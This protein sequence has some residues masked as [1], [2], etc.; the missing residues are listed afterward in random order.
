[1]KSQYVIED[2][3]LVFDYEFFQDNPKPFFSVAKARVHLEIRSLVSASRSLL[4]LPSPERFRTSF[5]K[6][7]G[8]L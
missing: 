3:Q 4:Y 2:P 6:Y 5:L 8:H 7:D 1:L